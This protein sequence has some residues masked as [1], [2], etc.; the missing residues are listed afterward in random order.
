MVTRVYKNILK[1]ERKKI[2]NLCIFF[3]LPLI[4]DNYDSVTQFI[5]SNPKELRQFIGSNK[6]FEDLPLSKM[7]KA[8]FFA[9][10]SSKRGMF[11]KNGYNIPLTYISKK[12]G[13]SIQTVSDWLKSLIKLK[14][15]KTKRFSFKQGVMAK[16]YVFNKTY[17]LES[18]FNVINEVNNYYSDFEDLN[19]KGIEKR[20]FIQ[21]Q[22]V[23]EFP[24]DSFR[25]SDCCKLA[26]F[27]LDSPE[28]FLSV[29][30]RNTPYW[31][32]DLP[33]VENLL[34]TNKKMAINAFNYVMKKN[35]RK[36][37]ITKEMVALNYDLRTKF[38]TGRKEINAYE[39]SIIREGLKET[40][41]QIES[42]SRQKR[43]N[44]EKTKRLVED[45][46]CLRLLADGYLS[47]KN[48]RIWYDGSPRR[49]DPISHY[50]ICKKIKEDQVVTLVL[51]PPKEM[52]E[53]FT[54]YLFADE[55]MR[56]KSY[57]YKKAVKSIPDHY[58][59]Y[60]A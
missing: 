16:S 46:I 56:K 30:Y 21:E 20:D 34:Q 39:E 3:Q 57:K 17:K 5:L 50:N 43:P 32:L 33:S 60:Y 49:R 24:F 22:K 2:K 9:F 12:F 25:N 23:A 37:R 44:L 4:R 29:I 15:I 51:R 41:R 52:Y 42:I 58:E 31:F 11:H 8:G 6:H 45:R 40:E 7:K 59:H 47:N 18:L 38:S 10:L 13:V 55:R 48:G 53:K 19:V 14:I 26:Q 27:F 28:K 35:G 54:D 1:S 36:S